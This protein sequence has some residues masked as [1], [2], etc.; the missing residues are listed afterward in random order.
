[1]CLALI[2]GYVDA[3]SLRAFH[4]Y[5]SFMSGNTTELGSMAGQGR[6]VAGSAV[7]I[8]FF[9]WG[10]VA[11]TYLAHSRLRHS[12]Q[13]FFGVVAALLAAATGVSQLG[14]PDASACI[15]T[16]SFAMGLMNATLPSIGGESVGLTFITGDLSRI[17]GHLA[18]AVK[19]VPLPDAQGPWDTQVHRAGLLAIVWGSFLIGAVI[20]GAMMPHFGARVLVFPF[21]ILVAL[22]MFS[23]AKDTKVAQSSS[24]ATQGE[25]AR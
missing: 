19:R 9:V 17:G 22:A 8:L 21:S 10:S 18:L 23:W 13:L 20:S 14:A 24:V 3:Y 4:T 12:R 1:M 11:G 16:L 5:V 25:R 7:A 6:L 2:A 15:A